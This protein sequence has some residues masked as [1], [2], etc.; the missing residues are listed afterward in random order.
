MTRHLPSIVFLACSLACTAPLQSFEADG[1]A[2]EADKAWKEVQK[3][4]RPPAPPE[5][6]RT[7][8]PTAEERAEFRQRQAELAGEAADK[9]KDFYTRFPGHD[10]ADEARKK[11]YEL[12]SIAV[13]LG[14]TS[15]AA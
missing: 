12:T 13:K 4:S 11:E 7:T 8:K 10:K 5:E 2:D 15:R 3:A 1:P 9:A 6:W 14:G